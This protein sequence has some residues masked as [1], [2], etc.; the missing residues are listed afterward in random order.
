[1][2]DPEF[3][4]VAK[5]PGP[6]SPIDRLVARLR[7]ASGPWSRPP[8][9]SS[10]SSW[11]G[12]SWRHGPLAR[13][14]RRCSPC[15]AGRPPRP[16]RGQY[17]TLGYNISR[18]PPGG[19]QASRRIRRP[20]LRRAHAR[21]DGRHYAGGSSRSPVPP[22][23][24]SSGDG[25]GG[26]DR[27]RDRV[28]LRPGGRGPE[29]R[30]GGPHPRPLGR[31]CALQ[32]RPRRAPPARVRL[33]RAETTRAPA[34]SWHNSREDHASQEDLSPSPLAGGDYL[35]SHRITTPSADSSPWLSDR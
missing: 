3:D 22:R 5:G 10:C 19:I 16:D 21:A 9:R 13:A 17:V 6:G 29:L 12:W 7:G 18:P 26:S 30:A 33:T 23:A 31:G 34:V 20:G 32:R 2:F 15:R 24:G 14:V 28:V 35:K 25:D 1:M 11:S 4:P 27:L 8:W